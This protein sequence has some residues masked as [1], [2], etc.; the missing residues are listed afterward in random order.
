MKSL[1][2]NNPGFE[3]LQTGFREWLDILGYCENSVYSVPHYLR[4]FLHHLE[5]LGI[6]SVRDMQQTHI[7]SFY[8][9]IS[10]RPHIRH[11]TGLSD[12]YIRM[13]MQAVQKFLEYLHHKG[14]PELPTTGVRLGA[15]QKKEP[16]VLTIEEVKM[17]FEV[18]DKAPGG[19]KS[20]VSVEAT[21]ARDKAM[22]AV[23][24]SCGLRSNEGEQL[25]I[26]DINFD[27]RIL[28]VRK[29]KNYK[30]RFV[31]FNKTN[32]A[33]LQEYIYDHRPQMLNGPLRKTSGNETALF[34]SPTGEPTKGPSLRCRLQLLQQLTDDAVLQQKTVGL[35]TLR[36]S[37]A[38]HLLQAG[39][40]LENIARFLGHSSLDST[41]IYTHI[42]K[43]VNDNL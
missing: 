28:H 33:Y 7:K 11:A 24:Y 8:N 18:T 10:Q 32:A 35:H 25:S 1:P 40:S 13:H 22:L 9:H 17:L 31:P 14:V 29:G 3:H 39:M 20:R 38:T 2:L 4:S 21:S 12:S 6:N 15:P 43:R 37:I 30:E 19:I 27:T 23:Y 5:G 26:D 42:V 36:H 16:E 34:I 41:Q